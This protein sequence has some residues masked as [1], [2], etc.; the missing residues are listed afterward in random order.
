MIPWLDPFRRRSADTAAAFRVV[1]AAAARE[2]REAMVEYD[3]FV[4]PAKTV[5]HGLLLGTARSSAGEDV[6][7]RRAWGDDNCGWLVQGGTGTGKTT[8][9]A[10][11]LSQALEARRPFGLIDC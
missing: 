1:E 7:L 5:T 6:P 2:F 11:L 10:S 4:D 3:A 8:W 9:V